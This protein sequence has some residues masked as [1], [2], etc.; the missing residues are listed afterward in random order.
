MDHEPLVRRAA[1]GDVN[2]FVEL[3]RRFQQFAF[4]SALALVRD[5]PQAE[6]VVQEA[7]LAAWS[8]LPTLAEPVAFPGWFRSIVR[9][10]AFRVLR[11]KH[12]PTAPLAEADEVPSD[13]PPPDRDVAQRRQAAAALA[14]IAQ[15]PAA[16]REPATLFFVH[17]CSHQDIA[18]FLGLSA[19]TVNNRLHAART[20]LKERMMTMMTET[21]HSHALPDDFANRI[22][23]LVQ[24]R[25]NLVE[26]LFDPNSPPDFLTELTLSDETS[27]GAV[28]AQVVQRPGGGVVRGIT[29]APLETVPRGATVLS[30]GRHSLTPLSPAGFAQMVPLLAGPSPTEAGK[31]KVLETG[32]KVID[33]MCPLIAGGSATIAGVP[34]TGLAVNLEEIVRRVSGGRDPLFMFIPLAQSPGWGSSHAQAFKE[35]GY[36]DGTVGAVQTF[37]FRG[38]EG[39]WTPERLAA[40][41]PVDTVIHLSPERIRA[42]MY[43][44]VDVLTSRSRLL[45][46]KQA[47]EE[48][49][50]VAAR[51]R[52]AI[53]ALWAKNGDGRRAG[54]PMLER[55][56]KLQFYFTQPYFVAEEFTKRPG[57]HVSFTESLATCRS[58]LDGGF[59]DVPAEAFFFSGDLTEIRSNIGRPL[60]FEPV[61]V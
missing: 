21:L 26:I 10:Q 25:G 48:H 50:T 37:L 17:E 57:T 6:D 23:R 43:P 41:A 30:S 16:L 58:I 4:G 54:D 22:G 61:G 32:I 12:V 35:D 49:V 52:E 51:V 29:L 11:K 2:A 59:D 7:F 36:S 55:A 15:L 9:R 33:V 3:T 45:E 24:A 53:A 56:R 1:G 28:T 27:G 18:V 19:T 14:A 46:T 47:G 60:P 44:A 20:Q 40:L 42:R 31:A 13:A 5:F 38:E 8:A 34:G 39:L